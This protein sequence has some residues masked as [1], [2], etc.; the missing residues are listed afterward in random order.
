VSQDIYGQRAQF[1]L[2]VIPVIAP[3][4]CKPLFGGQ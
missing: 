4:I 2:N 1:I 3:L